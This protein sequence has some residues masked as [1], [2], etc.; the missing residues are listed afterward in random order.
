MPPGRY[1]KLLN[2]RNYSKMREKQWIQLLA[3][4]ILMQALVVVLLTRKVINIQREVD[5]VKYRVTELSC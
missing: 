5:F 4:V 1:E 3:I 2:G